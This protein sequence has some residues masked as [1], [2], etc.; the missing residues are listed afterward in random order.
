LCFSLGSCLLS[1]ALCGVI[2]FCRATALDV[3]PTSV[4]SEAFKVAQQLAGLPYSKQY[5]A[6]YAD[7][8]DALNIKQVVPKP[9]RAAQVRAACAIRQVASS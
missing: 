7:G 2:V 8:P 4:E 3:A 6:L 1:A 5:D 9:D